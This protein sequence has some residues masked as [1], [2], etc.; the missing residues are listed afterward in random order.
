M[1]DIEFK[2]G[3]TIKHKYTHE[4]LEISDFGTGYGKVS[5]GCVNATKSEWKLIKNKQK[6]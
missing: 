3:D 5:I 4:I 6:G 2:V 1:K